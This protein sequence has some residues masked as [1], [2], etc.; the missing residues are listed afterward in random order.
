MRTL[1]LYF[2]SLRLSRHRVNTTHSVWQLKAGAVLGISVGLSSPILAR[3]NGIDIAD[4]SELAAIHGQSGRYFLSRDIYLNGYYSPWWPIKLLDS[5]LNGNNHSIYGLRVNQISHSGLFRLV[6]N[7]QIRNLKLPAASIRATGDGNYAGV[8]AAHAI[9]ANISGITMSGGDV[10]VSCGLLCAAGGLVGK[11]MNSW[12]YSNEVTGSVRGEGQ[13]AYS[14]GVV[15]WVREG[16]QVENNRYN[17]SIKASGRL[18]CAG[19]MAGQASQS[20]VALNSGSGTVSA[21]GI[22]ARGG[23]VVGE[24]LS[25]TVAENSFS[26]NVST[27]GYRSHAGGITGATEH[28]HILDNE[29]EVHVVTEGKSARAG[30]F[31]GEA[32]NDVITNNIATTAAVRAQRDYSHAGGGVGASLSTTFGKNIVSGTIS[33]EGDY[34]Y[35]GGFIGNATSTEMVENYVK[36]NI[37]S[38]GSF[39][40]TG[41]FSGTVV[42]S[43]ISDNFGSVESRA[44]GSSVVA[45][46]TGVAINTVVK[47]NVMISDV[48]ATNAAYGMSSGGGHCTGCNISHNIL[49][50]HCS[51]PGGRSGA[52][53]AGGMATHATQHSHINNNLA[54]VALNVHSDVLA[55]AVGSLNTNSTYQNN[56]LHSEISGS[57]KFFLAGGIASASNGRVEKNLFTG[58]Y[59]RIG[60]SHRYSGGIVS[61]S[62]SSSVRFNQMHMGESAYKYYSG[63]IAGRASKSIIENNFIDEPTYYSAF[64]VKPQHTKNSKISNNL[65][66]KTKK[67][68]FQQPGVLLQNET[69]IKAGSAASRGFNSTNGWVNGNNNQFPILNSINPAYQDFKRM[70]GTLGGNIRFPDTFDEYAAPGDPDAS[71]LDRKTWNIWPGFIPFLRHI[72]QALAERLGIDCHPG[73]L[74]C[75][76]LLSRER[77]ALFK[78]LYRNDYELEALL[79]DEDNEPVEE[80]VFG[81]RFDCKQ[82]RWLLSVKAVDGKVLNEKKNT[83]PVFRP[84]GGIEVDYGVAQI[85]LPLTEYRPYPAGYWLTVDVQSLCSADKCRPVINLVGRSYS[86]QNQNERNIPQAENSFLVARQVYVDEMVSPTQVALDIEPSIAVSETAASPEATPVVADEIV[87]EDEEPDTEQNNDLPVYSC[88]D[89]FAGLTV[90]PS[91]GVLNYQPQPDMPIERGA[92]QNITITDA[93]CFRNVQGSFHLI[94]D[95]EVSIDYSPEQQA[96]WPDAAD[97]TLKM[98][99]TASYRPGDEKILWQGL[100][101]AVHRKKASVIKLVPGTSLVLEQP[102]SF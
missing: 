99:L 17:G 5:E 37:S 69:M 32:F 41:G 33:T 102:A 29:A 21:Y 48:I 54:I 80:I 57:S 91:T 98:L 95:A 51:S 77:E 30:G 49:F 28:S 101:V 3:E 100:E 60:L 75:G 14:G 27:H 61:K 8:L 7:S 9:N 39:A 86:A 67:Y 24:A 18:A 63:D 82:G 78:A 73:G 90:N 66:T 12:F 13:E 62:T 40:H 10:R 64:S 34:A 81:L 47:Q 4:A 36:A 16:S 56:F 15:G 20:T 38:S 46:M 68:Y 45:G 79:V 43:S 85:R 52:A 84:S 72:N 89:V 92:V 2:L 6:R 25:A 70:N 1:I 87:D 58:K 55:G 97:E 44:T 59:R 42:N 19:S 35:S 76:C 26:G 94:A 22:N 71:L 50:G 83:F 11:A 88:A 96:Q 74:A 93:H 31:V 53:V 23:G 65:V